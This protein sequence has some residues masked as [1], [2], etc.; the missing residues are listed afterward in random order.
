MVRVAQDR[1][2][3]HSLQ[4]IISLINRDVEDKFIRQT[5]EGH[6]LGLAFVRF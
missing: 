6:I 4:A 3:T 5:L 1:K 2:G